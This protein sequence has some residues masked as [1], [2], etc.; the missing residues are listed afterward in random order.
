VSR[1]IRFLQVYPVPIAFLLLCAFFA[2]YANLSLPF[3]LSEMTSRLS[4]NLLLTLSLVIPVVAGLGLNFGIVLG[5]MAGQAALILVR[6]WH[7]GGI[8]GFLLAGVLATP[9]AIVLGFMV[10]RLL[11]LAKG[12]EM[13]T[14]IIASFFA[15]GVYSLIF[16]FA[17]GAGKIANAWLSNHQAV[18][19]LAVVIGTAAVVKL[20]HAMY[21]EL[22]ERPVDPM[23]AA[24]RLPGPSPAILAGF[25]TV[26]L[27]LL[28]ENVMGLAR[29]SDAELLLPQGFGLRTSVNLDW[30]VSPADKGQLSGA[31]DELAA[32]KVPLKEVVVTLTKP[33]T[34]DGKVMNDAQR[35]QALDPK[36][37]NLT[38]QEQTT[39]WNIPVA[40]FL[41]AL[42]VCVAI[43]FLLGTKLGQEMR[44]LGQDMHIAGVLGIEVDRTR[45]LAIILS[46]VLAA[47]GQMAFLQNMG[48]INVFSSHEQVGMMAVA[49][50]LIGGASAAEA[51]IGHAIVGTVLLHLLMLLSARAGPNLFPDNPTGAAQLGEYVRCSAA[52]GVIALALAL[53]AYKEARRR[54]RE[55]EGS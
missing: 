50:L 4:R 23:A 6:S 3:A 21:K 46:T 18:G 34:I 47:W 25:A 42:L 15:N 8:T 11:N 38:Q 37:A 9:A 10:G 33:V 26:C 40:S 49:A 24:P 29:L 1:I 41:A 17:V 43:R 44:A 45:I 5:A 28:T 13:I 48:T 12:R 16:L 22:L 51:N 14:G 53:H 36:N 54:Q 30:D 31:L 19:A 2:Q 39:Q 20:I 7:L 27:V 52:Y 32:V 55:T 35:V